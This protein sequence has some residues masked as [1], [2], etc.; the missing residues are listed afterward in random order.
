MNK[1]ACLLLIVLLAA[2]NSGDFPIE[3]S[4]KVT[5]KHTAIPGTRMF[6]IAPAGYIAAG[7]FTGLRKSSAVL[8]VYDNTDANYYTSTQL[9]SKDK[10]EREGDQVS[11]Y[12]DVLIDGYKGRYIA[13]KG[14]NNTIVYTLVFGDSTFCTTV[15]GVYPDNDDNEHTGRE[16]RGMLASIAYDAGRKVDP[17]SK[18][19]FTIN[20]SFSVFKFTKLNGSTYIYTPGGLQLNFNNDAP[21][22]IISSASYS[23]AIPL[24]ALADT[25]FRQI[26][27]GHA[28]TAKDVKNAV[29]TTIN[30]NAAY[31]R[32]VYGVANGKLC[33]LYELAMV[34]DKNMIVFTG[35]CKN[36]FAKNLIE[37]KSLAQTITIK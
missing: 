24:A 33:L 16:L 30:N 35:H 28:M 2:C 6:V 32:E 37:F 21:Y 25:T 7:G 8:Q 11:E 14:N 23:A 13:M 9:Y 5:A 27:D 26:E 17:F 20:D 3:I 10:F 29:D 22:V 36:D 12:K 4:N 1:I 31:Q 15:L 18:A 34:K 19:P